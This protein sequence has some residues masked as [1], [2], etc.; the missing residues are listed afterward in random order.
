MNRRILTAAIT[1]VG[2]AI[3]LAACSSSDSEGTDTRPPIITADQELTEVI[4]TVYG[5]MTKVESFSATRTIESERFDGYDVDAMIELKYDA[6][7]KTKTFHGNESRAIDGST[8]FEQEFY[9]FD[10]GVEKLRHVYL[11]DDKWGSGLKD[12]PLT[13]DGSDDARTDHLALI[14]AGI[15]R[16]DRSWISEPVKVKDIG[17]HLSFTMEI[18]DYW[19][20][21]YETMTGT[22]T[23]EVRQSTAQVERQSFEGTINHDGWG[24]PNSYGMWTAPTGD[25]KISEQTT[26][27]N[28]DKVGTIAVPQE[29]RD[30][31]V[32]VV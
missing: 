17:D 10:V 14:F 28:F 8:P 19:R 30:A 3:P 27:S 22:V 6:D 29:A 11:Q 1:S 15:H 23:I 2:L 7:A 25:E 18:K 24:D 5:T 9:V 13:L 26:L 32:V 16:P 21:S 20:N 31:F 12:F 4:D